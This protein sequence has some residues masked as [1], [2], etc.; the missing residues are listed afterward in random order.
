MPEIVILGA[1]EFTV[2]IFIIGGGGRE[3]ALAWKIRLDDPGAVI[4]CAPGNAGTAAIAS[5]VPIQAEDVEGLMAWAEKEKPDL[6]VVGPEAPLC[7]GLADRMQAEGLRVFGPA[8]NAARMEGSKA[9]AK[10]IL[11]AAQVPTAA[12]EAFSDEDSAMDFVRSHPPPLVIKAD[13]LAAGKG[14][15]I[16]KTL[17]EA[18]NAIRRMMT[19]KIFGSAGRQ[20]LVEEFLEGEE[21]SALAFVDGKSAVLLPTARDHKR[22]F[23]GDLGPNTGG[24]GAY[25]PVPDETR[26]FLARVLKDVFEPTIRELSSRGIC[27]RGVLYAGLMLTKSGPK[28]LEFNCRFGDPETQAIL[29]RLQGRLITA[30]EACIDGQLRPEHGACRAES[31]ACVVMAAGGYP[32][33]YK[34]GDV[35]SG[36]EAAAK[37]A[38][39]MIF[40]AGTKLDNNRPVTAG[41]RV[42]GV[43]ALGEGLKTAV[44][45]AYEA[46]ALINFNGA[47]YRRD[48]A[49]SGL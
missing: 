32:G 5:N 42:L 49:S 19:E 24:M 48:I 37:L 35:I 21:V 7:L 18:E 36:L 3:H 20:V 1:K 22:A 41:G 45:R 39:V 38:G 47:H 14:V 44:A 31:C 29:P 30:M 6:T 9:F 33:S 13:G 12:A 43:T 46:A 8:R 11:Q 40:H 25:S 23:D 28:V 16:C 10:E 4:F 17:P 15:V 2:K 34:K 26:A 27:Y